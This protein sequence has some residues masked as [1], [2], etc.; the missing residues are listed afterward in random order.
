MVGSLVASERA[1]D[2]IPAAQCPPFAFFFSATVEWDLEVSDPAAGRLHFF[3]SPVAVSNGLG[4]V[5]LSAVVL[6]WAR[7]DLCYF[8]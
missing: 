2:R 1:W 8:F 3:L 5:A 4:L 7:S 6:V